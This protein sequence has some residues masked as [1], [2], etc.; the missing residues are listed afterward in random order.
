M[1][2]LSSSVQG[3]GLK[4]VQG[5][6]TKFWGSSFVARRAVCSHLVGC[7]SER[8]RSYGSGDCPV[9]TSEVVPVS[10]SQRSD[11]VQH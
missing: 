10:A 4:S 11:Y 3:E 1:C 6:H 9:S 2:F 8:D 5:G 7:K